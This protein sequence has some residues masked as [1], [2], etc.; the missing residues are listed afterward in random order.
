MTMPLEFEGDPGPVFASVIRALPNGRDWLVSDVAGA[1][2]IARCEDTMVREAILSVDENGAYEV[3]CLASEGVDEFR[4]ELLV[5][6][7]LVSCALSI[8]GTWFL[9]P[10]GMLGLVVGVVFAG[11]VPAM[12]LAIGQ[13]LLDPGRD[14]GAEAQLERALRYS[15]AQ[16]PA[17][18]LLNT[19]D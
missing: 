17:V 14:A 6:A 9:G 10:S 7:A 12:V 4:L 5:I 18:R 1:V 2:V 11:T 19:G 3:Q 13:Q 15:I 16:T 8:V